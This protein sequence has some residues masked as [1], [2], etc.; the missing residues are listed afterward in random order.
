MICQDGKK[1]FVDVL[2]AHLK[3]EGKRGGQMVGALGCRG[4]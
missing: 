4:K 1:G 2:L 3:H